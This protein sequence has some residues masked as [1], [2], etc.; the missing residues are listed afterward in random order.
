MCG[1]IFRCIF[2][3]AFRVKLNVGV[4][5]CL[6]P[7]FLCDGWDITTVEGLGSTKRGLHKIQSNLADFGGTQ[8]GYCSPGHVMNMYG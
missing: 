1:D 5:Q 8:C 6:C 3:G 4:L 2:V 7:L